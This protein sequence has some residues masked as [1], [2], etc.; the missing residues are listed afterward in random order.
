MCKAVNNL[1][2]YVEINDIIIR[3]EGEETDFP[4]FC[5]EHCR[6][7]EEVCDCVELIRDYI[8]NLD[9]NDFEKY[10]D[11]KLVKHYMYD[12]EQLIKKVLD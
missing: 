12:I 4:K 1:R 3:L 11:Y 8:S 7:I 6:D 5:D 10:D 2:G 9:D